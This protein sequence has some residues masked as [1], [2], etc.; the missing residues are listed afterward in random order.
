MDGEVEIRP[1]VFTDQD[2]AKK[3]ILD[4]LAEHYNAID[5]T[6]NP[7]LQNI[8]ENYSGQGSLFLVAESKG[9]LIGTGALIA[10]SDNVGRIVRVSVV[11]THRRMGVGRL[12]TKKLIEAASVRQ[13]SQLVVETNEDW[14]DAIRLYQRFGFTEY[15]RYAGEVHMKL[16]L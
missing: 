4:G 9:V 6:L 8:K 7:D 14:Y 2:F 1:F 13:Y 5:P 16:N 12:I 10:E 11:K 3:L 15:D